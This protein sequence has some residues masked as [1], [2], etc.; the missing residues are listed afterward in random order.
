MQVK[1]IF[2]SICGGWGWMEGEWVLVWFRGPGLDDRYRYKYM[3]VCTSW[4]RKSQAVY[5]VL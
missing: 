2:A 3:C 5:A 1:K 4:K